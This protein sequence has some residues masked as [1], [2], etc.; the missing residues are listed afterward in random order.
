M[1]PIPFVRPGLRGLREWLSATPWRPQQPGPQLRADEPLLT[2]M[3]KGPL[4]S[5][6]HPKQYN[7]QGG[8]RRDRM[9]TLMDFTKHSQLIQGASG[10]TLQ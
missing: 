2:Q 10:N 1:Y 5:R 8:A 9:F 4:R 6:Y 3:G 7:V